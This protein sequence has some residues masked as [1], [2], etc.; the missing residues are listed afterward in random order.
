GELNDEVP[1]RIVADERTA[2]EVHQAAL[3]RDVQRVVAI[4]Q[5]IEKEQVR[6]EGRVVVGL[7]PWEVL[8]AASILDEDR[9]HRGAEILSEGL[10][11]ELANVHRL[12]EANLQLLG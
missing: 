7:Q 2:V 4:R 8:I 10:G 5:G 3:R 6:G 12:A 9:R 1:R 11:G